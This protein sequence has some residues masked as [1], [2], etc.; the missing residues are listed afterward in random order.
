MKGTSPPCKRRKLDIAD[1]SCMVASRKKAAFLSPEKANAVN[2]DDFSQELIE[3]EDGI[4]QSSVPQYLDHVFGGCIG[5]SQ[6][7]GHNST[8]VSSLC[9]SA[10]AT[11]PAASVSGSDS[12]P[13]IQ[14]SQG[15]TVTNTVSDEMSPANTVADAAVKRGSPELSPLLFQSPTSP[16]KSPLTNSSS[17][18]THSPSCESHCSKRTD[19]CTSSVPKTADLFSK[20]SNTERE[21]SAKAMAKE[22]KYTYPPSCVSLAECSHMKPESI[23]SVLAIIL[24][25]RVCTCLHAYQ[26]IVHAFQLMLSWTWHVR[27]AHW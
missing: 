3:E 25:G 9:S 16:S 20:R 5:G 2:I 1:V 12:Y 22:P 26:V 18:Q 21:T 19:K 7:S 4:I 8:V 13:V 10:T 27:K 23:I 6:P 14:E 11:T 24:Q 17:S 15:F